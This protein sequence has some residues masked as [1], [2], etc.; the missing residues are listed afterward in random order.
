MLRNTS[1]TY[2][3]IIFYNH[4]GTISNLGEITIKDFLTAIC[5]Q[6]GKKLQ[7]NDNTISFVD[8]EPIKPIDA[9]VISISPTSDALGQNTT[10][11]DAE[12]NVV[13]SVKYQNG[14]LTD[15]KALYKSAFYYPKLSAGKP[16]NRIPIYTADEGEYFKL[17]KIKGVPL[18]YAHE[19]NGT[20]YLGEPSPMPES[21]KTIQQLK[22]VLE[23]DARTF[24]D[25]TNLRYIT[26]D[27]LQFAIID[28]DRDVVSG[29]TSF[30]ALQ[31]TNP[32]PI[33]QAKG[34]LLFDNRDKIQFDNKDNIII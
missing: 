12:G 31:V 28:S 18:A 1:K 20:W 17:S 10:L 21:T 34:Y 26:I 27:G 2:C 15:K 14:F 33:I 11:E 5:W 23:I 7:F 32:L 30:R 9:R 16:Y 25:I 6:I 24:D 22:K 3:K 19:V 13:V 4:I 29:E 8:V